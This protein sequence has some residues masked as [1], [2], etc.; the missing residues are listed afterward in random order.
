M[1]GSVVPAAALS[2]DGAPGLVDQDRSGRS[3][4]VAAEINFTR[5]NGRPLPAQSGHRWSG[6]VTVPEGGAYEFNLQMLGGS[7]AMQL[8][9]H[10]GARI[11][12]PPQHGDVLQAG[13]DNVLPTPDGLDNLRRRIQLTAGTHALVVTAIGDDSGQPLQVRLNWASPQQKRADYQAA[14]AAAKSAGTVVVF[15]WSRNEP[16]MA[17]P[18]DQDRLIAEVAAANPNTI[19]VLNTGDPVVMPWLGKVRAVL[20]MWYTGDEGGWA[21]A[22]LLLGRANP[23]GRLP[24]TWPRRLQ[25]TVAHDASHPER[26]SGG[27]DGVTRYSEGLLVGYRWFDRERLEPLFAFGFGLS[28]TRFEYQSLSVRPAADGGLDVSFTLR[29]IG[30]VRGDEV[31]QVYLTAP[32]P[33]PHDAQFADRSLVAFERIA[34]EPRQ[35]KRV[36]LH[37]PLR[38]LQYW[39]DGDHRWQLA[40]G[41]RSIQVGSSSRDIRLTAPA[42]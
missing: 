35:S 4:G 30:P 3:Q 41:R 16:V 28:Y 19:V 23:A 5:S 13:Q 38:R 25:D 40:V 12:I 10:E 29:N 1:N 18:G 7:G 8:D 6:S 33:V 17:L 2:H 14:I 36:L 22:N 15:A 20:Q 21:A 11:A 39:S 27:V 26:S 24:F 34:L 32:D 42:G 37:L 31:P 9:G